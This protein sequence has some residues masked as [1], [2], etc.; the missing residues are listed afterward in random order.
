M[1]Q[2]YFLQQGVEK[3]AE[4]QDLVQELRKEAEEQQNIL[5]EKQAKATA[6]LNMISHTMKGANT[7][8]DEMEILKIK[9]QEES[10]KL[11]ER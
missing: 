7:Q 11:T 10:V 3:L 5:E 1:S 2:V 8:K 9:I 6:S 4:A